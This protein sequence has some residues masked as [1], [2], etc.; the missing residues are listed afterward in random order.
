MMAA[1]GLGPEKLIE[2]FQ[3]LKGACNTFI[4]VLERKVEEL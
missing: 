3:E 1:T 4:K 2:L